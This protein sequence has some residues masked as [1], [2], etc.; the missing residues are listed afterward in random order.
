MFSQVVGD[1][2]HSKQEQL[3]RVL[4]ELEG[5]L[6]EPEPIQA[7]SKIQSTSPLT[8]KS[9]DLRNDVECTPQYSSNVKRKPKHLAKSKANTPSKQS[10]DEILFK[11]G[12]ALSH[13]DAKTSFDIAS[14]SFN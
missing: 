10:V 2:S 14:V 13:S 7:L 4:F 1:F 3:L 6:Q 12:T 9:E 8:N 11:I 5:K